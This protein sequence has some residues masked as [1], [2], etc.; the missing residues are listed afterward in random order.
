MT[1]SS[2]SLPA[3]IVGCVFF[4]SGIGKVGNIVA[5]QRLIVEYGLGPLNVVAPFIVLFE[6]LLGCFLVFN[7]QLKITS[8]ISIAVLIIFSILY[9]HAWL[10]NGITDC[11]CFG[12]YSFLQTSPLFTLVRN[13]C[14]IILLIVTLLA[15]H[16]NT[17]I[18]RWKRITICTIMFSATFVS[19]M[20]YRPFAFVNNKHPFENVPITET[21]LYK[22]SSVKSSE[23]EL[24]FFIS[25]SC[26]HCVNSIENYKAWQRSEIVDKTNLYIVVDSSSQALD[27][28]RHL[29]Q[30]RFA[31]IQTV[32]IDKG[33][34]NFIDAYP[35]AFIVKNDTVRNV[36]IGE[37]PSHYLFADDKK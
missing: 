15:Y 1:R 31:S 16:L 5:F 7:Y 14:L 10:Y 8:I 6:L 28:L 23:S 30:Q 32:E 20:T 19:G 29:F 35:T 11:G 33:S 9:S 2:Y 27:S 22:Y 34:L 17:N 37:L 18:E 36:I 26:P 24:I 21:Q 25:Y 4:L 13:I 12:N 3:L